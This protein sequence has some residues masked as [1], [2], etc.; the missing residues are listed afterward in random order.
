MAEPAR[1]QPV[2]DDDFSPEPV[3]RPNLKKLEGGG[4]TT[5][6]ETGHLRAVDSKS[7]SKAESDNDRSVSSE[8]LKAKEKTSGSGTTV[9]SQHEN[10]IGGGFSNESGP[11]SKI[12]KLFA[13]ARNRK[14]AAVGGG[15]AGGI[16]GFLVFLFVSFIPLKIVHMVENLQNRFMSTSHSAMEATTSNLVSGMLK[17]NVQQCQGSV[18]KP[19][20]TPS[21]MASATSPISTLYKTWHNNKLENILRDKYG[22]E[23]YHN[24]VSNT[25]YMRAPGLDGGGKDV[26]SF[27]DKKGNLFLQVGRP[28]LSSVLDEAISKETKWKNML[29]RFKF[30][31][32]VEQKHKVKRCIGQLVGCKRTRKVDTI[33]DNLKKP[34]RAAQIYL[35]Q[36]VL[37][38][39]SHLLGSAVLCIMGAIDCTPDSAKS[40]DVVPGEGD[41]LNGAP[42]TEGDVHMGKAL[43]RLVAKYLSDDI[44]KIYNGIA[45]DG[46]ARYAMKEVA[47][48]LVANV[49]TDVVKQE[50]AAKSLDKALP[51][52]GWAN[53]IA[54]I[55]GAARNIGP[56][57]KGLQ[58]A[59]NSTAMVGTYMT[60]RTV[61]DQIKSG[62]VDPTEV[63][64]FVESLGPGYHS[65]VNSKGKHLP[66]VGGTATAESSPIYDS[67]IE[68]NTRLT[69]TLLDSLLPSK[70][71][72]E[73]ITPVSS[74]YKCENGKTPN[75]G[76]VCTE[77]RLNGGNAILNNI[78]GTFTTGPLA[79][80]G[81]VAAAWN[82]TVG[83]AINWA[84]SA[85]STLISLIP[86]LSSVQEK[87]GKMVSGLAEPILNKVVTFLI[88]NPFGESQ[89]GART[90][91]MAAGGADVAGNGFAHNGLG[92]RVLTPEET[93]QIINEQNDQAKFEFG[94][95][96][97]MARLFDKTSQ[98]SLVSRMAMAMPLS[99]AAAMTN[100][101]SGLLS[102]PF[103]KL[104]DGFS[105]IFIT[106]R[107]YAATAA[108]DPFGV[109]QYGYTAKDIPADPEAYWN[110]HC[111]D[112]A[113]TKA[114]NDDSVHNINPD[115]SQPEN[116][117]VNGCLLIRA[118]ISSA[119]GYF[120]DAVMTKDDLGYS[121]G[122]TTI[123]TSTNKSIYV[124]GDSIS[125]GMRDSGDLENKLS[126]AGWTL[127]APIQATTGIN[128]VNSLP[129]I[130]ADANMIKDAD[131]VVVELGTN[132]CSL[133]GSPISCMS[134]VNFEPQIATMYNAIR[135][136]GFAG[137]IYWVNIYTTKGN[138]YQTIN[139]AILNQSGALN[140]KVINWAGQATSNPGKYSF[141]SGASGAGVH[142]TSAGG[143]S[144]MADFIVNSL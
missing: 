10:Q 113:F 37:L 51:V 23:I 66:Q 78:S 81:A 34:K 52:V 73:E 68:G 137:Q 42:G 43:D 130:Q 33:T 54:E 117:T 110:A 119:G 14:R 75:V 30:G 92:G 105:S 8:N 131:A 138:V 118:T 97:L 80:L 93:A 41:A 1:K 103:G 9:S 53:L 48:R 40:K 141:D 61:A 74:D 36:R 116:H 144:N 122:S 59:V 87:V 5:P 106:P 123:P 16:I 90:F 20:C 46:F 60:Y 132:N 2:Y 6:R 96:P 7:E 86:G 32:Y 100:S 107:V 133:Y 114:W 39:R 24:T 67:M 129:K 58:Y 79:P 69:V 22:I 136:T 13:S 31:R 99:K 64:S 62:H 26:H 21:Y 142:Q 11:K 12:G 50:A 121:S 102:N 77:E 109:S 112:S 72:A 65:D 76:R 94:R 89:S 18:V 108:P 47:R 4:E 85:L 101:F 134:T 91:N 29:N 84:A 125:V 98:F 35:A 139:Q 3:T 49:T 95:K 57:V 115:T 124:I 128:V 120:D 140:F 104:M 27:I 25:Y 82:Q 83:R 143:W 126:T 88:P 56:T 28:E 111:L 19:G 71:Y 44:L 70:A 15:I 127:V 17:L 45:D 55:I 135:S 38:P 63:G